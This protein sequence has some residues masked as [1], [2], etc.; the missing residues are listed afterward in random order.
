PSTVELLL[1]NNAGFTARDSDNYTALHCAAFFGRTEV[2]RVLLSHHFD[3]NAQEINLRTPLHLVAKGYRQPP[4]GSLTNTD[5]TGTAAL[6]VKNGANVN[7]KAIY[8]ATPLHFAGISGEVGVAK[9]LLANGAEIN[10]HDF[11]M[12]TPLH[13]AAQAGQ[14][15]LVEL[16]LANQAD[17]TAKDAAGQTPAESARRAGKNEIAALIESGREK[18]TTP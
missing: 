7:K 16:L 17:T 10:A 5:Y 11:Q 3:V 13:L 1:T 18:A 4:L 12:Q 2:V 8:A 6:L 14:K 9:L 15:A